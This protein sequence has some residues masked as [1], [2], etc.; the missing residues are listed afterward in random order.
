MI[1]ASLRGAVVCVAC[2]AWIALASADSQEQAGHL[3][4]VAGAAAPAPATV[5]APKPVDALL[6]LRRAH[7]D[8]ALLVA[9]DAAG[10]RIELSIVPGLQERITRLFAQYQV[11]YGALVAIEPATGRVL[12]YV[13]HSSANPGAM[14][15]PLD[16]TAP[17]ASVFKV[18]TSSALIDAGVGPET[19]VC[20][21][22]GSSKLLPV[23]LVD[24]PRHDGNCAS[25]ADALGHSINTVFAKLAD[26]HLNAPTLQRYAAAYGFGR[27]LPFVIDVPPSPADIPSERMEFARSAAGFWH[28]HMSPL[29]AALIAATLANDGLMPSASLVDRVVEPDGRA[30]TP[31]QRDAPRSVVS[32][33]TA[34]TVGR[35]MLRT[36]QSGTSRNAFLDARGRPALPGIDVAGKTGSLSAPDPYRAYS[37]WIGFAPAEKPSI[38][39][40]VLIVNTATWRIKSSFVARE[41]LH[42]YL[43]D[44]HAPAPRK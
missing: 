9:N 42:E 10:R 21:G 6:A 34:H 27:H 15:L 23:D 43:V 14:D 2:S 19:R 32:P 26:R 12:A 37:W 28:V 31:S 16:V 5:Q 25:L 17:A 40:A 22:G 39:L 38:A 3:P 24:N 44:E 11:P 35:M 8:G 20:Y 30:R 29:H 13:S 41:A 18:V 1:G 36:V 4:V 33:T 7:R